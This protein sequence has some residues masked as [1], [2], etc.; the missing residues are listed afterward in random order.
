MAD[1]GPTAEWCQKGVGQD[2]AFQQA[3]GGTYKEIEKELNH[4][5]R[6]RKFSYS[7]IPVTAQA[8][9]APTITEMTYTEVLSRL[10]MPLT[11]LGPDRATYAAQHFAAALAMDKNYGPAIAGL[12]RLD[13]LAGRT[14]TALVKDAPSDNHA[15]NAQS[16]LDKIRDFVSFRAQTDKAVAVSNSGDIDA[17]IE[18][19]EPLVDRAPEENQATEV[20]RFLT[21]LYSYRD[22][23]AQYNRAV[24]LVNGG[25]FNGAIAILEP[26]IPTVPCPRLG[27]MAEALLKDL[28]RMR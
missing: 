18:I 13:E 21:K 8:G 2:E 1:N 26:P 19:L 20:R 16:L 5:V 7:K 14:D 11:T 4:Y 27:S 9:G 23:Q 3:L 22:F 28:N 12:G 25:D 15:A 24:D 6:G 10:G 17:A